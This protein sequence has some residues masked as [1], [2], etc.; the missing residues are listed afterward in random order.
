MSRSE[1]PDST[2]F[3][4]IYK[5]VTNT[6]SD[7]HST[8]FTTQVKHVFHA[9]KPSQKLSFMPFERRLHNKFLL[10]FGCRSTSVAA[11]LREGI[12]M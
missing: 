9:E 12:R 3:D 11:T 7:F 1:E 5:S 8:S 6:S 10:W 2:L 4:V